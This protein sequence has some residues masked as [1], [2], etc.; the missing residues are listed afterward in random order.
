MCDVGDRGLEVASVFRAHES[1]HGGN[2]PKPMVSDK[3]C[4]DR[5]Q[6]D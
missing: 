1:A 2:S 6:S 5:D 3:K 4:L